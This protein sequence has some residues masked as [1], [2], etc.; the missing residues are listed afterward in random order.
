MYHFR[1]RLC[2]C[3]TLHQTPA[4]GRSRPTCNGFEY[5]HRNHI[6]NSAFH[7]QRL[8]A[9]CHLRPDAQYRPQ[10]SVAR[11][12]SRFRWIYFVHDHHVSIAKNYSSLTR[13]EQILH[14]R[15]VPLHECCVFPSVLWMI[16][17]QQLT[18]SQQP[19]RRKKKHKNKQ[20]AWS[21]GKHRRLRCNLNLIGRGR[22]TG[23][24]E[25]SPL[26]STLNPATTRT[27]TSRFDG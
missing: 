20:T 14:S 7:H 22:G 24:L 25:L 4:H 6:L 23:F 8:Q 1:H 19:F 3:Q 11:L 16:N 17:K 18:S 9:L 21:G 2:I 27:Q 10:G 26:F 15:T 12:I 13:R 5:R